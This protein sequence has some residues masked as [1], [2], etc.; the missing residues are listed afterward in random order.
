MRTGIRTGELI[1]G[2]S[3]PGADVGAP[4]TKVLFSERSTG[5]MSRIFCI[6]AG[7]SKLLSA[8]G[9]MEG[10]EIKIYRLV[11]RP[12]QYKTLMTGCPCDDE[13]A[14]A[15]TVLY[16]KEL[17][18]CADPVTMHYAQDELALPG[19]GCYRLELGSELMLGRIYLEF[20]SDE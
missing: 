18:E 19:P 4:Q 3:E 10:D 2:L 13:I 8:Y 1:G 17:R 6:G 15:P 5:V 9:L 7:Q 16:T 20:Q 14:L 11:L 12:G